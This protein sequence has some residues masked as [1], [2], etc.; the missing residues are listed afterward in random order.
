MSMLLSKK[1]FLDRYTDLHNRIIPSLI[2]SQPL[3]KLRDQKAH[4]NSALWIYWHMIRTEDVGVQRFIR[5][6]PELYSQWSAEVNVFTRLNG[7]GMSKE[8]VADITNQIN[9]NAL[10]KYRRAVQEA[11]IQS[12]SE[13][14][15]S[16]L[17]RSISKE[18]VV[19][20]ICKEGTMPESTWNLLDLYYGKTKE[21]FLLH[22]CLTHHFYHL[23]Q[24][25]AMMK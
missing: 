23:G 19:Q 2:E 24:I 14:S 17:S 12:V 13:F 16:D 20:I 8:Q 21:W 9:L 6:I 11:T 22:V 3:E 1:L 15:P 10:I 7:T 18:K 25:S 4:N 5:D